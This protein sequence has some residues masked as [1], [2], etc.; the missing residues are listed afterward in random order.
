MFYLSYRYMLLYT[1]QPKIDTKGHAYT[2]ALQHLLTGIYLAELCLMGL[3]SIRKATGP[4]IMIAVLLIIT[5]IYNA[6]M[7]RYFKPLEEYLP[8]NLALS[9]E[10]GDE[11]Q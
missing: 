10:Q 6:A 4:S 8:L 1:V 5:I 2:L 7:N 9:S 3:F 11:E